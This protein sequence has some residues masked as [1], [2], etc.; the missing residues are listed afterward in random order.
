MTGGL[1]MGGQN[2]TNIDG[3]A[4]LKTAVTGKVDKTTT[5][6]GIDLQDNITQQE[7]KDAIGLATTSLSGLLSAADKTSLDNLVALLATD[8]ADTVVNTIGEVLAIFA[9]YPEGADLVTALSNK[10][11]VGHTHTESEITDL[12]KYTQQE[13]DTFLANK[14]DIDGT[15]SELTELTFDD[16]VT[17]STIT[18]DHDKKVLQVTNGATLTINGDLVFAGGKAVGSIALGDVVQFAGSQGNHYLVKKAVG[19]EIAVQPELILGIAHEAAANNDYLRVAWFGEVKGL[20]LSANQLGDILYFNTTTS[21]LTTTRPTTDPIIQLAAVVNNA[22]NGTLL[23]R[24]KFISRKAQEIFVQ[25]ITNKFGADNVQNLL[26]E[27][28]DKT[29]A[30]EDDTTNPHSVTATQ[31]GAYTTSETDTLLSGKS[32][33]GHTHTESDITDLDKYTQS[34]VDTFLSGK[35]DLVNGLIPVSQIPFQ[36]DD[37]LQGYIDQ[38]VFYEE[39]TFVTVIPAAEGKL[40]IDIATNDIYRYD[41]SAYVIVKEAVGALGDIPDVTITSV[42]TDD[43][44]KYNGSVWV[45]GVLDINELSDVVI[46]NVANNQYLKYDNATGKWINTALDV[47][48]IDNLNA[49]AD[50][51]AAN[52]AQGDI[53]QYNTSTSKWELNRINFVSDTAPASPNVGDFWFDS[54]TL[55][56]YVYYDDGDSIQWVNA[57]SGIVEGQPE[58]LSDLTDVTLGTLADGEVLTYNASTQVWEN[59]AL[60]AE[61]GLANVVYLTTTIATGDWS[62][63][64]PVTAVKTVSGILS[65]DKPLIDIDLSAVAFADVEDKQ[66]EYAKI[67]RVAATDAN[68]ITFYAL[69]AP[70]EELVIQIKVVR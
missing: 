32:D 61:T 2:I 25:A 13:V 67:Y 48:T 64:D 44:L 34:Q 10:S 46:T 4:D 43:V 47:P 14:M 22:N 63:T 42:Q 33:V 49:I 30:H 37:V 35:A 58:E 17:Q 19:S 5:I 6:A 11:D 8:D 51:N 26:E 15:N 70:T 1:N 53:L 68:E 18:Y 29:Q 23:V 57:V 16:G 56:L 52:A 27:L 24:P 28:Y 50:V 60:P 66:T 40:Y 69:E 55:V 12:D 3:I 62:G 38:G 41:G 36:F 59:Q 39:A 31:V 45:N 20:N 65:T 7:V 21:E 54:S 9:Q